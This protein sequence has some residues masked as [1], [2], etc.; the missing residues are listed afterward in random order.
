MSDIPRLRAPFARFILGCVLLGAGSAAQAI[1]RDGNYAI[2]GIGQASCFQYGKAYAKADL[3]AYKAYLAGYLTAY[4]A[5]VK[6][7]YQVTG[8][9]TVD[10]NLAEI[11]A[12][13][14]KNPMDSYERGIQ[15]LIEAST[16]RAADGAG[17]W[18][19]AAPAQ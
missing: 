4:N 5:L 8:K 2:W 7:V 9:H 18:G 10:D 19:R 6:D 12:H 14:A 15:A 1:D 17:A 16:S 13:C 3:A 11:Q